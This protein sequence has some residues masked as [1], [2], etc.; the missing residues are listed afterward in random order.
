MNNSYHV[1]F[2]TATILDWKHLLD[3]NFKMLI[4]NT[5]EW[6][7]SN[8]RCVIF[9]FVIMPNH[10]H[11]LWKISDDFER[12]QVQG[13]L[14]SYT[15]HVFKRE[16]SSAGLKAL[17]PYRVDLKDRTFQFWQKDCMVKECWSEWFL[18]EKLDYIHQNPLQRHWNLAALP[19]EYYWSSASFY[20]QKE[21][22]FKFLTHYKD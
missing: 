19:E 10:L 15:A 16:L 21:N 2:L 7:T 9:G 18:E 8:G 22:P 3:D 5:M 13:A 6:L 11:L 4:V 12:S 1:E 17:A 14:L 20:M